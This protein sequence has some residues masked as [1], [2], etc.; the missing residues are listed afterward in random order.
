MSLDLSS[1]SS[2]WVTLGE[3]VA[4]FSVEPQFPYLNAGIITVISKDGERTLINKYIKV[5]SGT[6][7]L[8]GSYAWL[9]F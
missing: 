3:S 7:L 9:R 2:S 5:H 8:Y 1:V 4:Y 6:Y